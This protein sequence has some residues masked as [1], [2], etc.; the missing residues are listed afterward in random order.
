[1]PG[2]FPHALVWGLEM[3]ALFAQK[4]QLANRLPK[5]KCW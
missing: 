2:Q 3:T 5:P 4:A 1:V